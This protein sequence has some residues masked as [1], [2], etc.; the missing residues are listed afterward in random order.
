MC[1]RGVLLFLPNIF[2]IIFHTVLIFELVFIF[3]EKFLQVSRFASLIVLRAL[4]FL[5]NSRFSFVG[6]VLN[7][8]S[9]ARCALSILVFGYDCL[10]SV[11]DLFCYKAGLV[12]VFYN[13]L[14]YFVSHGFY[15]VILD[16]LSYYILDCG[17][18]VH[19]DFHLLYILKFIFS[20]YKGF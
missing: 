3:D 20:F 4:Q 7:F 19:F 16:V 18:K 15:L 8:L 14:Y 13:S 11:Y 5:K 9:A 2:L 10:F 1:F 6:F 17:G 12:V